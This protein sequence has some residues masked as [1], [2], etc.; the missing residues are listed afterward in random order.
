[1]G[2]RELGAEKDICSWER[3]G[4][5]GVEKTTK[6]RRSFIISKKGKAIPLQALTG[7]EGSRR[8]RLP[9]FKT[10]GGKVVSPTQR[11]PLLPGSIPGTHL[12]C[13]IIRTRPDR[14]WGPPSLLYNGY[15]VFPGGK[16]AWAWC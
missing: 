6:K 16:A 2:V 13:E 7:P 4:Y 5:R 15:R 10:T 8:L 1:M 3:R 12:C 11:P 14:P 9:D